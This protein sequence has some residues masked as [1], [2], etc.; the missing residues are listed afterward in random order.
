MDRDVNIFETQK[1]YEK[2][3][4]PTQ[5][6]V[7]SKPAPVVKKELVPKAV[8]GGWTWLHYTGV[9]LAVVAG[10]TLIYLAVKEYKESKKKGSNKPEKDGYDNFVESKANQEQPTAKKE[11]AKEE[12][13]L[14]EGRELRCKNCGYQTGIAKPFDSRNRSHQNQG[15]WNN[16]NLSQKRERR[17]VDG[18]E[19]ECSNCGS[20]IGVIEIT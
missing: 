4:Q 13:R 14:I 7:E 5:P 3:S 17:L 16:S 9:A 6:T 10:G 19:L 2:A 18:T 1:A 15:R 20:P 11:A 8:E 12:I